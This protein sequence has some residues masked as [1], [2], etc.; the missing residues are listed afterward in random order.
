MGVSPMSSA[1]S[2]PKHGPD[3]HATAVQSLRQ[4]E[5]CSSYSQT[6]ANDARRHASV[7]RLNG[8]EED[9]ICNSFLPRAKHPSSFK[10][11]FTTVAERISTNSRV[12]VGPKVHFFPGIE[13]DLRS[14]RYAAFV[15][16]PRRRVKKSLLS[17]EMSS[18]FDALL[19]GE[20]AAAKL[21]LPKV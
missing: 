8:S 7:Q 5:N 3:A 17:A 14:N 21:L 20:N 2:A 9:E 18:Q 15:Q 19:C 4:L 16:V 13:L 12:A 6:F 11:G 1:F 10:A